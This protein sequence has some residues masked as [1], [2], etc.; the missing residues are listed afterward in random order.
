MP[1]FQKKCNFFYGFN[2]P[3]KYMKWK[4]KEEKRTENKVFERK[5][6]PRGCPLGSSS[7]AA[8]GWLRKFQ[9]RPAAAAPRTAGRR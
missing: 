2:I 4:N 5:H 6:P 7:S 1:I 9:R 3:E 8:L